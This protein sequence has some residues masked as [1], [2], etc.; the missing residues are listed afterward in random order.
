MPDLCKTPVSL[1][2]LSSVKYIYVIPCSDSH[3][4]ELRIR[5]FGSE[6]LTGHEK[7]K[8]EITQEKKIE[9]G[10]ACISNSIRAFPEKESHA[11]LLLLL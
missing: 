8:A 10:M 5:R 9:N 2:H 7:F 3:E 11:Q 6:Q 4:I 1:G